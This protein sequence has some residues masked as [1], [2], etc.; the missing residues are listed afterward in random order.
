MVQLFSGSKFLGYAVVLCL[1]LAIE[2]WR[3]VRQTR[4][5]PQIELDGTVRF[6]DANVLFSAQVG[7][8]EPELVVSRGLLEMLDTEHLDAVIAHEQG[9]YYYRIPFG[10]SGSDGCDRLHL[11]YRI[12][13][14]CGRNFCFC[15]NYEPIDGRHKK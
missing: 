4:T 8:W 11:F 13:K 3:S 9:H 7:F 15:A 6:L 2:G 12:Q 5:Y 1:K 14:V 10:F